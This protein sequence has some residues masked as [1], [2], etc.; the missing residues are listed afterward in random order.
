[1]LFCLWNLDFCSRKTEKNDVIF[2]ST[3]CCP[4][5][6]QCFFDTFFLESFPYFPVKTSKL[7]FVCE[8]IFIPNVQLDTGRKQYRGNQLES[9]CLKYKK[10]FYARLFFSQTKADDIFH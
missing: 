9:Y 2:L 10:T 5:Q 6:A 4:G 7:F 1:M 3:K 8:K